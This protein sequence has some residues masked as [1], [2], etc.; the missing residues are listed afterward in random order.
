MSTDAAQ[1]LAP[2]QQALAIYQRDPVAWSLLWG[3]FLGCTLV[4]F[5]I[6]SVL[7]PNCL[8]ATRDAIRGEC[9]PNLNG[10][11]AFEGGKLMEDAIAAGGAT[12]ASMIAGSIVGPLAT[13]VSIAL[14]PAPAIVT[15]P[16]VG[17]IDALQLAVGYL[18]RQPVPVMVHGLISTVIN[19]PGV[20]CLF[21]LLV[22][23]PISGIA[24][25]LFYEQHRAGILQL[26]PV[27]GS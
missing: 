24:H 17:G 23:L 3:L 13:L 2:F 4:T 25:W 21:P 26:P 12:V 1:P 27:P 8:R 22:T 7:L 5:G 14:A 10:L 16:D 6:G 20:C 19:I 15:E 18:Q 11:F 9:P